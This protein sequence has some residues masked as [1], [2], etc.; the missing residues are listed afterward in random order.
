MTIQYTKCSLLQGKRSLLKN[1]LN[2]LKNFKIK[3]M[4][5]WD[6]TVPTK[7]KAFLKGGVKY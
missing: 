5:W 4:Q 3:Y 2:C 7:Y 1:V 6:T